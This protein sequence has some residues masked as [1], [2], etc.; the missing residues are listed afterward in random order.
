[1]EGKAT[2]STRVSG[3]LTARLPNNAMVAAQSFPSG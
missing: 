3:P 1:M 2:V